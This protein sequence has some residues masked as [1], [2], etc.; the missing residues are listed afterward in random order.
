MALLRSPLPKSA[1]IVAGLISQH[2]APVGNIQVP[3]KCPENGLLLVSGVLRR[4]K[5]LEIRQDLVS[6]VL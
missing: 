5:S 1:T 4:A 2:D 6:I 3:V